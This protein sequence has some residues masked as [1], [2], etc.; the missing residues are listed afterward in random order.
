MTQKIRVAVLAL[1]VLAAAAGCGKKEKS[2]NQTVATYA[3]STS[4]TTASNLTT[5]APETTAT[6]PPP[7]RDYKT[8]HDPD[9]VYGTADL[10]GK[11]SYLKLDFSGLSSNQ[12]NRV[13]HR[14]RTENCTCGC[15]AD[16][17]DQCLV[18][19]PSCG[20]A[21]T[22]ANQILREEKAKS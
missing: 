11:G 22:L 7:T 20:V 8:V 9:A 16:P 5:N 19:D 6:P 14:M 4:T 10:P 18:N 15:V 3:E 1:A 13:I 21:V 12:L 2:S 17:I